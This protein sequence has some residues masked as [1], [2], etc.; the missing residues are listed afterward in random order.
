VTKKEK[1]TKKVVVNI[2]VGERSKMKYELEQKKK[3]NEETKIMN[4]EL[5]GTH[6]VNIVTV[7]TASNKCT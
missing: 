6:T 1:E 4:E 7:D 2:S 5:Y 3:E